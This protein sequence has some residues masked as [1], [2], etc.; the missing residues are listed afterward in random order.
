MNITPYKFPARRLFALFALLVF[1]LLALRLATRTTIALAEPSAFAAQEQQPVRPGQKPK[2]TPVPS[3]GQPRIEAPIPGFGKKKSAAD[4]ISQNGPEFPAAFSMSSF[5]VKGFVQGR[6][7]IVIVY[8]LEADSTALL[9]ISTKDTKQPFNIELLPA[10]NRTQEVI[11]QIPEEFGQK[12]TV[13]VFSF[14]AF[15]TVSGQRKPVRF[16]LYGLGC[17][18][19]A[20]GSMVVD[21]LQFQPGSIHPKLKE[22]ASYSFRSLS[23]FDT[24]SADFM[25]VSLDSEGVVRSELAAREMLKNGV[26]SG[27][28]IAREWDG[29]NKGKVSLGP[30]QLRVRV[31]RGLKS[32]GDWV[33]AATEQIV[34]VE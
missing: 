31:W 1:S 14:Q 27:E 21:Q 10:N 33:F 5:S 8:E 22:K 16:F 20:V 2:P 19:H 28:A 9:T 15:K 4:N 3:A 26:R 30:H 34:K 13:G 7:P 6:W 24:A 11:S 12:P 29:K 17:G 32:G 18:N 23:D 25:L